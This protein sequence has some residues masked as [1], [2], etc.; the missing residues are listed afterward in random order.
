MLRD[1]AAGQ[2]AAQP[3]H[4]AAAVAAAGAHA[5]GRPRARRP[6][7]RSSTPS[8]SPSSRPPGSCARSRGSTTSGSAASTRPT[9]CRRSSPRTARRPDLRRLGVRRRR[10]AL[11]P[12]RATS[13]ALGLAAAADL[14]RAADGRPR[15]SR[16]PAPKR[17]IAMPGGSQGGG[18]DRVLPHRVPRVERRR[19]VRRRQ[20]HPRLAAER[21]GAAVP[22]QPRRGRR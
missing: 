19:G 2:H 6:T 13:T 21:A 18:D 9:S 3:R 15:R 16:R 7:S 8:G 14:E 10:R 17:P 4:R 20:G 12:A 11:V 22:A 1:A 5:L